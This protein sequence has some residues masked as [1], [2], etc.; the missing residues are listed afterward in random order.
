MS[1]AAASQDNSPFWSSAFTF[2]DDQR[3]P[4]WRTRLAVALL[5]GVAA[6]AFTALSLS[7]AH[8][9][10][11]F[12]FWWRAARV[13]LDGGDPYLRVENTSGWPLPDRLF[14]PLPTLLVTVPVAW[15]PLPLA[16]G[17][18]LGLSS[19]VLAWVLSREGLGR[20]WL[21]ATPGFL[22]ALKVGQWSPILT[23]AALV[24]ALGWLAAVKPT[25]GVAVL[26]YHPTR[27][28][29]VGALG[30]LAVSV[31]VLPR[32]PLEW[33]ANLHS[34]AGH[35]APIRT[36]LGAITVLAL[37]CWREPEGRLLLAMAC[38]PQLL[39]FADQLPLALIARSAR[40]AMFLVAVGTAAW[41]TWWWTTRGQS[42][43]VPMAAPFVIVGTYWPSLALVLRR[44]LVLK[45]RDSRL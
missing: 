33:L 29:I 3:F 5:I 10:S 1:T 12:E 32:W 7:R 35:P 13:L 42:S 31:A 41:W 20:L 11:D 17:I 8:E 36:I 22:M 24:P 45:G 26:A 16:A 38:V 25:L 23:L 9:P 18:M 40:E 21:F 6:G 4:R 19:G 2:G 15:M 34:V 30:F 14:Y 28:A 44:R 39:F 37:I 43:Y 27:R